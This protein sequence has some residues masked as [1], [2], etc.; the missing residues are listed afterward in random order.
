MAKVFAQYALAGIYRLETH[1][2]GGRW[3]WFARDTQSPSK[4]V[5]AGDAETLEEAMKTAATSVGLMAELV[6]WMPEGP[7][8]E[9]ADGIS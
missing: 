3:A 6:K 5:K 2:V 8:I 4:A 7:E 9:I 1:Y